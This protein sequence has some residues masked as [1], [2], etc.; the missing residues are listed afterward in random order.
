M[1]L[2]DIEAVTDSGKIQEALGLRDQVCEEMLDLRL[3][4]LLGRQFAAVPQEGNGPYEDEEIELLATVLPSSGIHECL[5][6]ACEPVKPK[7]TVYLLK[8]TSD[9]LRGFRFECNG[10]YYLL[11]AIDLSFTI[12]CTPYDW[13][14][15]A[16]PPEIVE[17]ALGKN[18]AL[19]R[20]EFWEYANLDWPESDKKLFTSIAK[21]YE[22]LDG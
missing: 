22:N 10:F 21:R 13:C 1:R 6:I 11:L 4:W 3:S 2:I 7:E 16:G 12:M 14:V 17:K 15:Y 20:K 18:I 19:A 9:G 8:S 5:A